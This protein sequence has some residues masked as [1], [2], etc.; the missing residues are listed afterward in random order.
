MLLQSKFN[1]SKFVITIP[2][3]WK[4][5][6]LQG[7]CPP[8]PIQFL[9]W[10]KTPMHDH[11]TRSRRQ[12]HLRPSIFFY[13][14]TGTMGQQLMAHHRGWWPA[15]GCVF[16][17]PMKRNIFFGTIYKFGSRCW[18][19]L[20]Q[21]RKEWSYN[22][23]YFFISLHFSHCKK[24]LPFPSYFHFSSFSVVSS[25]INCGTVS[26][27]PIFSFWSFLPVVH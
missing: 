8:P 1:F 27:A 15:I 3:R 22:L 16:L 10:S 7:G 18:K 9:F 21:H 6:N 25:C 11:K 23:Y 17:G 4:E 26:T 12:L 13:Q 14:D 24:L 19:K 20:Y 2:C 5:V